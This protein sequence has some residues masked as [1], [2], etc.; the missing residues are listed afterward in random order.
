MSEAISTLSELDSAFTKFLSENSFMPIAKKWNRFEI[1][2]FKS[3]PTSEQQKN[4]KNYIWE[5]V[6]DK[7][8]LYCYFDTSGEKLLYVGKAKRL[9]KRLFSHYTE[10]FGAEA[11][12][13]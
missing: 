1:E 4:F 7:G 10:A 2:H 11:R 13:I 6:G 8:G 12:R 9:S 5:H 3:P